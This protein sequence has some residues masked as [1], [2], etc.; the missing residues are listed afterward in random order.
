MTIIIRRITNDILG[1]KESK[2]T[3]QLRFVAIYQVLSELEE[4]ELKEERERLA[5][6][7]KNEEDNQ[8]AL[9]IVR[10]GNKF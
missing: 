7:N 5:R 6:D 2:N 10:P 4:T 1:M 3:N 9:D 8:F